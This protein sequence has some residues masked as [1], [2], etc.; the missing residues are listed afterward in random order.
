[1]DVPIREAGVFLFGPFRLDPVRRILSRHGAT[2]SLSGRLFDTLLYL[3]QHHGRLVGRDELEQAIWQGR[4]VEEG[5]L[6]KAISSLRKALQEA[7]A[8]DGCIVTVTGRGYHFGLPVAFEPAAVPCP[9]LT[10][11]A[12]PDVPPPA[13]W[14]FLNIIS[15]LVMVV[16]CVAVTLRFYHPAP[17]PFA[18]PRLSLVVMPFRN[19]SDGPGRAYL[20]D[21]ITDDLTTDLS[22]I[23][24]SVVIART[25]A[26]VYKGRP[27]NAGEVGRAL[28][29]RY[30]LEGSLRAA[31][32]ALRINA[33]LIDTVTGTHVWS[34][35]YDASTARPW[36]A[37]TNIVHGIAS[38]LDVA[39]V[40][41]EV[42]RAAR[43][44][45]DNPDALDLFFRARS[46]IDRADTLD[47][48]DAAQALLE[49]AIKAEPNFVDALAELGTLLVRKTQNYDYK[50]HLQD[51]A[52][53]KTVLA[54]AFDLAKTNP[55][56]LAARGKLLVSEG[57]CPEATA[58]FSAALAAD[59]NN[60]PALA[61][62]ASCAWHGG[63]PEQEA[64]AM[65]TILRIDPRG[66]M[67][68]HR[69]QAAGLAALFAGHYDQAVQYLLRAAA[70]EPERPP[71]RDSLT[72]AETGQLYL[73]ASYAL[74]GDINEAKRRCQAFRARWPHRSVWRETAYF[75]PRQR[76]MQNFAKVENALV[77]AG[78]P[79]FANEH[80]DDG[81]PATPTP[82]A[83][84]DF[85]PTPTSI[86]GG[87]VIDTARLVSLLA[88][89][90][91]PLVAETGEFREVLPGAIM[92]PD[93]A[94][95]FSREQIESAPF[96]DRLKTAPAIV[97]MGT[98]TMGV[99][100]YNMALHFIALGYRPV[101]WYRGG[102]EAWAAAG[103]P[104]EDRGLP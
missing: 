51:T 1:M 15:A 46:I 104:A 92:L 45:P 10:T 102:E 20:A 41:A 14:R 66:P 100:S 93:D 55:T 95:Q 22:H 33:Q 19:L 83:G 54:H 25:S 36:D 40:D 90:A 94:A 48:L 53:A 81:V 27:V 101:Y 72:P 75:S 57:R 31:D 23:P 18:P 35:Y 78:M 89:P 65:G 88:G 3:V 11:P 2:V 30:L 28:N 97:V 9:P 71:V 29:V 76:Q 98:G 13:R 82:L 5:N 73:I 86:P 67:T 58:A 59:P 61:G 103:L 38:A 80:E 85:T 62:V 74:A 12:A 21:A 16:V 50:T 7:G 37:Q 42:A 77:A 34:Q 52:E 47:E 68:G 56:V 6:G 49:R 26:D 69:F 79:R 24:G 32:G 91:P 84:L 39:L 8:G 96:G 43:E 60:I 4:M 17:A 63:D 64:R 87:I 99:Q 44:R 70:L